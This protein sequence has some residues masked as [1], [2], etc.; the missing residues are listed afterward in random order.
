MRTS[1][2]FTQSE[3]DAESWYH[4]ID[5]GTLRS[6]GHLKPENWSLYG[7]LSFMEKLNFRRLSVLDVVLGAP[8]HRMVSR[9]TGADPAL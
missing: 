4:G 7:V 2:S 6:K 1:T 9:R 8:V 3:I 5:F